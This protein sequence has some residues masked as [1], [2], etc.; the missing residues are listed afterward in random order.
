MRSLSSE[1]TK[2]LLQSLSQGPQATQELLNNLAPK[3]GLQGELLAQTQELAATLSKSHHLVQ[4]AKRSLEQIKHNYQQHQQ[5]LQSL[6]QMLG[7]KLSQERDVHKSFA[8]DFNANQEGQG[9]QGGIGEGFT[10]QSPQQRAA[11]IAANNRTQIQK[12]A[13]TSSFDG[14]KKIDTNSQFDYSHQQADLEAI[15][16]GNI[17]FKTKFLKTPEVAEN[18]ELKRITNERHKFY[19]DMCSQVGAYFDM[20]KEHYESKLKHNDVPQVSKAH[21]NTESY[22]LN[23]LL[24]TASSL[25]Q[26]TNNPKGAAN[27]GDFSLNSQGVYGFDTND[28]RHL[29][30]QVASTLSLKDPASQSAP[31]SLTIAPVATVKPKVEITEQ[32]KAPAASLE[33]SAASVSSDV[34]TSKE[35]AMSSTITTVECDK[36]L[37][38]KPTEN[39]NRSLDSL[40]GDLGGAGDIDDILGSSV[41]LPEIENVAQAAITNETVSANGAQ[42]DSE[43]DDLPPWAVSGDSQNEHSSQSVALAPKDSGDMVIVPATNTAPDLSTNIDSTPKGSMVVGAIETAAV[44]VNVTPLAQDEHLLEPKSVVKLLD[45]TIDNTGGQQVLDQAALNLEQLDEQ[46]RHAHSRE[47]RE[48]LQKEQSIAASNLLNTLDEQITKQMEL[49]SN[50][51]PSPW[52]LE[53]LSPVIVDGYKFEVQAVPYPKL[54]RLSDNNFISAPSHQEEKPQC[55]EGTLTPSYGELL[56]GRDINAKCQELERNAAQYQEMLSHSQQARVSIEQAIAQGK[57][58]GYDYLRVPLDLL[59]LLSFNNAAL[60][61]EIEARRPYEHFSNEQE[62]AITAIAPEESVVTANAP[63]VAS[64][65]V[66]ENVD[67]SQEG[68][69]ERPDY[70]VQTDAFYEDASDELMS[71][72]EPYSPDELYDVPAVVNNA[73]ADKVV[74]SDDDFYEQVRAS[75]KWCELIYQAYPQSNLERFALLKSS[76]EVCANDPNHW[77]IHINQQD[78][79]SMFDSSLIQSLQNTF[80]A[81]LKQNITIEIALQDHTPTNAPCA[82][83][84]FE[85]RKAKSMALERLHKVRPLNSL[86]KELHEDLNSVGVTLYKDQKSV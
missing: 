84:S 9:A 10:L 66:A 38:I 42:A 46:V 56:K 30:S 2:E 20:L 51:E 26:V 82:L 40:V 76:C 44:K 32:V 17:G 7:K 22:K 85:H 33:L 12:Q 73:I 13:Q 35:G 75:D 69:W 41:A 48:A 29:G 1:D 25:E 74:L 62:S 52:D 81:V 8:V 11:Q 28:Q 47:E 83:A 36:S 27:K 78:E 14:H 23:D 80:S 64:A 71:V 4:E 6:H 54:E 65:I 16:G 3:L 34:S 67:S 68:E 86:L 37:E 15:R 50:H 19:S 53:R 79:I 77:I 63:A 39:A 60:L 5:Q 21:N 59:R 24:D 72:S 18:E 70:I 57:A 43:L 55:F 61:P 58:Q 49:D 45:G 31:E